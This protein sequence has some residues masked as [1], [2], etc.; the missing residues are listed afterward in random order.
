MKWGEVE[1]GRG[2]VICGIEV[3]AEV[4]LHSSGEGR[5]VKSSRAAIGLGSLVLLQHPLALTLFHRIDMSDSPS[6]SGS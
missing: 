1:G 6:V 5:A 2:F 3:G 4:K